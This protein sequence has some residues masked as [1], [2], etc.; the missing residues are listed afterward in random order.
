M[1]VRT[2]CEE[3]AHFGGLYK[4]TAY[5]S[6]LAFLVYLKHINTSRWRVL[7]GTS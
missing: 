4:L 7:S 5:E 6:Y 3:S 1:H 2:T